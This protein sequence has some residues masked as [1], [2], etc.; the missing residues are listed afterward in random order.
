MEEI[1]KYFEV[2]TESIHSIIC[3][4]DHYVD[5]YDNIESIKKN[6]KDYRESQEMYK[7][8]SEN[9]GCQASMVRFDEN[10][11]ISTLL[12]NQDLLILDWRLDDHAD[13]P[14]K[15][16]EILK[17]AVLADIPYV[18]IYTK[19]PITDI[20]PLCAYFFSGVTNEEL[21]H[22]SEGV[23]A[24]S[25]DKMDLLKS[26]DI[27]LPS[28]IEDVLVE[29]LKS[30]FEE[31]G[32]DCSEK[33]EIY[34]A[35]LTLRVN[36]VDEKYLVS[37]SKTHI[38]DNYSVEKGVLCVKDTVILFMQK[39]QI[40][41]KQVLRKIA[42]AVKE[43][44]ENTVVNIIWLNYSNQFKQA[45]RKRN[46][47]LQDV[48]PEAFAYCVKKLSNSES[49]LE[50]FVRELYRQELD[51]LVMAHNIDFPIELKSALFSKI[52]K[53]NRS[54][55]YEQLITINSRIMLNHFL[56]QI[57]HNLQL[58]DMFYCENEGKKEYWLCITA[59]CDCTRPTIN[60]DNDYL[61][62]RGYLLT[63]EKDIKRAVKEA[64]SK[65]D[66]YV[67]V[68]DKVVI[69][70]WAK[71]IKSLC[72]E[73]VVVVGNGSIEGKFR[74]RAIT[75][76]YIGT[77]KEKYVQRIVNNTF[78]NAERV[79]VTLANTRPTE[80]KVEEIED[81]TVIIKTESGELERVKREEIEEGG[82]IAMGRKV[83]WDSFGW[84]TKSY[85]KE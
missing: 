29:Q 85:F 27:Y 36:K 55:L 79:G 2:I 71:P 7:A 45:L 20:F 48:K 75:L 11:D 25:K 62:V 3:I 39:D 9:T 22:M 16:L 18:C 65:W 61:F 37:G 68:D 64:E 58:G 41:A 17:H 33:R 43:V 40:N 46:S 30:E 12:R 77:L 47:F 26:D 8:L 70:R 80:G 42:E 74:D 57:E 38:C 28:D 72:V 69:I 21:Q 78:S 32:I 1:S 44:V 73:N 15:T 56:S 81:N 83:Y 23:G 4:D 6:E 59:L 51:D 34:K 66:S 52:D 84:S 49:D 60:I 13:R 50:L 82:S 14:E 53:T 54:D 67:E 19:D 63:D 10:K 5:A 76:K 35:Y 24:L 31:L